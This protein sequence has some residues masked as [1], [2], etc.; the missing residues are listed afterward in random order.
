[1]TC[2]V[3]DEQMIESDKEGNSSKTIRVKNEKK[4]I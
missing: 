1:M 4:G 2:E 3:E